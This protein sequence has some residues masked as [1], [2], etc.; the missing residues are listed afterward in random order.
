MNIIFE[1]TIESV[2]TANDQS[3]SHSV[4]TEFS[5]ARHRLLLE[6]RNV[7]ALDRTAGAVRNRNG[8]RQVFAGSSELVEEAFYWFLTAPALVYVVYL[9]FGL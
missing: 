3:P 8:Q 7:P 2:R 5:E 4:S 1:P 9:A 6:N